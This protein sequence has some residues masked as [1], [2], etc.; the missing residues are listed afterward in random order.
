VTFNHIKLTEVVP[1]NTP[2]CLLPFQSN[3]TVPGLYTIKDKE[4]MQ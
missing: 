4:K 3:K 1:T 2:A